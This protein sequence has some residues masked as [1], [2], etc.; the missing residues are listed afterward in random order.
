[1]KDTVNLNNFRSKTASIFKDIYITEIDEICIQINA[2]ILTVWVK[3]HIDLL[4]AKKIASEGS[5]S[6]PVGFLYY[7][8]KRNSVWFS[9]SQ[10]KTKTRDARVKWNE[11]RCDRK[12]DGRSFGSKLLT[13][14]RWI[15]TLLQQTTSVLWHKT[16]LDL[17]GRQ[18]TPP[19]IGVTDTRCAGCY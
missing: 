6:K 17:F 13:H 12:D 2:F 19:H 10:S 1:M 4:C 18:W 7:W 5:E 9:W 14:A 11:S 16:D 8:G 15:N 3:L